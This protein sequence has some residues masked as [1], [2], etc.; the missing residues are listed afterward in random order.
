MPKAKQPVIDF[1]LR[2]PEEEFKKEFPVECVANS[3]K[4]LGYMP[5]PSF[6]KRSKS[7]LLEEMD[8]VGVELGVM[9]GIHWNDI[10]VTD[11]Q[12]EDVQKRYDGRMVSLAYANLNTPIKTV[13]RGIETSIVR[14]GFKGVSVETFH[15]SRAVDDK[16]LFPIY[17]KCL[18][19]GVFVHLMSGPIGSMPDLSYTDPIHYEHVALRYP[20]LKIVIFHAC[21][22]YVTQACALVL[23]SIRQGVP[24]IYLEPD[25]FMF[26]PG[27]SVYV[28]AMRAY[29]NNFVFASAYP[30]GV[31]KE[32]VEQVKAL[33]LDR[34]ISSKYFYEN[35]QKLLEL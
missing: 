32:S 16:R 3:L 27:G 34:K 4:P 14:R 7:L 5:A 17:E 26:A 1:R 10:H 13:L 20:D 23:R 22:P 30:Y 25:S 9:D 6:L 18:D 31:I 35:A 28:E 29:P 2:P 24:N 33:R 19:L 11:E 8:A 21:Y 15:V 12:V